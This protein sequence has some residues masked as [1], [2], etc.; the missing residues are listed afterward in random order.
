MSK[1]NLPVLIYRY[2]CSR[3]KADDYEKTSQH[4]TKE[5]QKR[6]GFPIL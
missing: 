1:K 2:T 4:F 6:W 5:Q 3:F